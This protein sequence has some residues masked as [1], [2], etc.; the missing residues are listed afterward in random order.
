MIGSENR[1]GT[2][3]A[4]IAEAV[5]RQ[6]LF[7]VT[8]E[9]DQFARAVENF[10]KNVQ[11]E[12]QDKP[13]K[14]QNIICAVFALFCQQLWWRIKPPEPLP[15]HV[16]EMTMDIDYQTIV[17]TYSVSK[18]LQKVFSVDKALPTISLSDN[19]DSL[20]HRFLNHWTKSI[21]RDVFVVPENIYREGFFRRKGVAFSWDQFSRQR[22]FVTSTYSKKEKAAW[23]HIMS[24]GAH[25]DACH[26]SLKPVTCTGSRL[27][28]KTKIYD[29]ALTVGMFINAFWAETYCLNTE[30]DFVLN[31][32]R[33]GN[34]VWRVYGGPLLPL[35]IPLLLSVTL[36]T[37]CEFAVQTFGGKRAGVSAKR[38]SGGKI[39]MED[40]FGSIE[41]RCHDSIVFILHRFGKLLSKENIL[42][43]NITVEDG[44]GMT[45]LGDCQ[46]DEKRAFVA[47]AAKGAK[48]S[49][50]ANQKDEENDDDDFDDDDDDDD[51]FDDDDNVDE[52]GVEE[53]IHNDSVSTKRSALRSSSFY[54]FS[55]IFCSEFAVKNLTEAE[56]LNLKLNWKLSS[57][58]RNAQIYCPTLNNLNSDTLVE[59]ISKA[60]GIKSVTNRDGVMNQ[61]LSQD[62]SDDVFRVLHEFFE[63]NRTPIGRM[64]VRVQV[65]HTNPVADLRKAFKDMITIFE[66]DV[67]GYPADTYLIL[68]EFSVLALQGMQSAKQHLLSLV[69][70]QDSWKEYCLLHTEVKSHG[71]SIL[72]GRS[73]KS[74][75][76]MYMARSQQRNKRP[77]YNGHYD[78]CSKFLA[79]S[80][81]DYYQMEFLKSVVKHCGGTIESFMEKHL[82]IFR[83]LI[84][85]DLR[86]QLVAPFK[87]HIRRELWKTSNKLHAARYCIH[88]KRLFHPSDNINAESQYLQHPCSYVYLTPRQ[89]GSKMHIGFTNDLRYRNYVETMIN[90][91]AQDRDQF[92]LL[93]YVMYGK[94][95]QK[96][97]LFIGCAGA[98]K[99]ML[100]NVIR[101]MLIQKYGYESVLSVSTLK[102]NAIKNEGRTIHSAYKWPVREEDLA[103]KMNHHTSHT[104]TLDGLNHRILLLDEASSLRHDELEFLMNIEKN[105]SVCDTGALGGTQTIFCMDPLQNAPIPR[106]AAADTTSVGAKVPFYASPLF[107]DNFD[108]GLL[109]NPNKNH[110]FSAPEDSTWNQLL[111]KIRNVDFGSNDIDSFESQIGGYLS[112]WISFAR[113]RTVIDCANAI[114]VNVKRQR[115]NKEQGYIFNQSMIRNGYILDS[116][117]ARLVLKV[118]DLEKALHRPPTSADIINLYSQDID[119]GFKEEDFFS[120][121]CE[122][123]GED[124]S[125]GENART[126]IRIIV[127]ENE[128]RKAYDLM[129]QSLVD[130]KYDYSGFDQYFS[131]NG[132]KTNQKT[133][134]DITNTLKTQLHRLLHLNNQHE[135]SSAWDGLGATVNLTIGSTR[136]VTNNTAGEYL[137]K[138]QAVKIVSFNSE[139][140]ELRVLPLDITGRDYTYPETVIKMMTREVRVWDPNQKCFIKLVWSQFPLSCGCANVV[141]SLAGLTFTGTKLIFDN[142]RTTTAAAFYI[143]CSRS[144]PKHLIIRYPLELRPPSR[145]SHNSDHESV[146]GTYFDMKADRNGWLFDQRVK[147]IWETQSGRNPSSGKQF[148]CKQCANNVLS[149]SC[150]A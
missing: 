21:I 9:A 55:G 88:C 27:D 2:R 125:S 16:H 149:C 109:M 148:R 84:S 65:S 98:G 57:N 53:D 23:F 138:G 51:D 121:Q 90:K 38:I 62:S 43:K 50:M 42:T 36:G 83:T 145:N 87:A 39:I 59:Q 15:I 30:D 147:A 3:D 97:L 103:N 45:V 66:N 22:A 124:G 29:C 63:S 18:L 106:A 127:T 80:A 142:T 99:S 75:R 111:N 132:D 40:C 123:A 101:I 13:S 12:N 19:R 71:N 32:S 116:R 49:G 61:R 11:R 92:N 141:N 74:D 82:R 128:Q 126:P 85:T 5:N 81:T 20:C 54:P 94:T 60:F 122:N 78:L 44:I 102:A 107:H 10:K 64:E 95:L 58:L 131:E 139:L 7:S 136:V 68:A 91:V 104:S 4:I 28:I 120:V 48:K 76:N 105:R 41:T 100:L 135:E 118:S 25:D 115:D 129:V 26:F 93:R 140:R 146:L 31:R 70:T 14:A 108:V 117:T 33:K 8:F 24:N 96:P 133:I 34:D 35:L 1:M 130:S 17:G 112:G 67:G 134:S 89:F 113:L 69:N 73:I 52:K 114:V 46:R 110:R 77:I 144:V 72:S 79:A 86:A 119:G 6:L 56:Q 37:D 143:F 47:F 150:K 137:V